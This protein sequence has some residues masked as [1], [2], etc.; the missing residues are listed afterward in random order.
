M[1]CER[2]CRL[3]FALPIELAIEAKEIVALNARA[4]V[5]PDQIFA[6]T[7]EFARA[8]RGMRGCFSSGIS[9]DSTALPIVS[10]LAGF[11]EMR[12]QGLLSAQ[13]IL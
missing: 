10:Y 1:Q 7:K 8:L 12:L 6:H 3:I 11:Q 2:G 4:S 9:R 13:R 5:S